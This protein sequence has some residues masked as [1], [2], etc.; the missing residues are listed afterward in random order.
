ML[1]FMDQNLFRNLPSDASQ[2]NFEPLLQGASFRLERIVSR[3][4]ATPAGQWYDQDSDEWVTLLAGSAGLR[5]EDETAVRVLAPGD[6]VQIA[7]GRR[8]R[9]EWTAPDQAT[10]WLALHYRRE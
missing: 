10:I 5:F 4:Q 2:E 6:Y 8:H 9:V 3:G 7:A 1:L